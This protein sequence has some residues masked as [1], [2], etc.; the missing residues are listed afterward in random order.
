MHLFW[1]VQADFTSGITCQGV[2]GGGHARSIDPVC[3]HGSSSRI[4]CT[5]LLGNWKLKT[6]KTF[7]LFIY[8]S[9]RSKVEDEYMDLRKVAHFAIHTLTTFLPGG[10]EPFAKHRDSLYNIQLR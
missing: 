4:T 1:H 7:Y 2:I 9:P 8:K 5:Q 6:T 3:V 10:W